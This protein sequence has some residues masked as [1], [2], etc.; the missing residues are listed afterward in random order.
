MYTCVI[1]HNEATDSKAGS[2]PCSCDMEEECLARLPSLSLYILYVCMC[3]YI[4]IYIVSLAP[5][6][7]AVRHVDYDADE[8]EQTLFQ[9]EPLPFVSAEQMISTP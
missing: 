9:C 5:A 6:R 7:P 8:R 1:T 2:S 3:I 4:Y